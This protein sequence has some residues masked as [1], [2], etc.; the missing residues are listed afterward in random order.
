MM[1]EAQQSLYFREWGYVR[2]VKPDA[3]RHQLHTEALGIDK[4]SKLFT[5][6]DLDRVLAVFR[7]ISR[8]ASM[9]SQLRQLGQRRE[10]MLYKINEHIR[11][12]SLYVPNA[13]A[14]A[15]Q[16][17][18]E[19]FHVGT[20]EELGDSPTIRRTA[21]GVIE[22][23]APLLQYLMTLAA[24]VN[25][26]RKKAGDTLHKMKTKAGVEC[27]CA[28]CIRLAPQAPDTMPDP[29]TACVGATDE[30]NPF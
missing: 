11:C 18:C 12:L 28:V 22:E 10:R 7:T 30:S 4:S 19:R 15:E 29:E 17:L 5:N 26:A 6:H 1:T 16:I 20:I 13:P 25:A 27:D 21:T 3:D 2:K 23:N 9:T 8:P 14:Y 24:R